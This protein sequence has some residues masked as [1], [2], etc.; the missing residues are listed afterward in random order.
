MKKKTTG[1]ATRTSSITNI[2]ATEPT[3]NTDFDPAI[4]GEFFAG[5]LIP[6]V[7]LFFTAKGISEVVKFLKNA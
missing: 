7:V 6:I 4:A 2:T 3:F 5:A 1:N